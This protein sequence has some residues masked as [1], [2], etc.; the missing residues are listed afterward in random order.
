MTIGHCTTSQESD[1]IPPPSFPVQYLQ[2]AQ[3]FKDTI[4]LKGMENELTLKPQM[5]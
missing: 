3:F 5:P 2:S 1:W 4:S